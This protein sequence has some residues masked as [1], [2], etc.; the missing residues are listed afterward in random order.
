MFEE[1]NEI[2]VGV[3]GVKCVRHPDDSPADIQW[4]YLKEKHSWSDFK[5]FDWADQ[6]VD[7][8]RWTDIEIRSQQLRDGPHRSSTGH[9]R[10][11]RNW[12]NCFHSSMQ[13][14]GI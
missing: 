13:F 12:L 7:R 3:E 9:R 1:R 2:R 6:V 11:F 5:K 10:F 8:S 4:N 14:I